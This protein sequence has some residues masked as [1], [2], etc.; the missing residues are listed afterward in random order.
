MSGVFDIAFVGGGIAA[1]S[2][3][4]FLRGRRSVIILESEEALGYHA[5]GRSAAEFAFRFHTPLAGKLAALSFPFLD[6]PPDGFCDG[7][8]LAPRGILLVAYA[9][10]QARL[11]EVQASEGGALESLTPE[12]ALGRAPILNP[13]GLAGALFDPECWDIDVEQLFQGYQRGVRTNGGEVRTRSAL[14]AAKR[15]AGLWHLETR[16]GKV[17]AR[18]VVN[19]SGAW[20]DETAGLCGQAPLGLMP[21]RRTAITVSPPEGVVLAGLPEIEDI[22]EDWYMK[23][24]AG[25]LLVSPADEHLSP[26][27]DARPEEIDV[28]WAM[29]HVHEAT[30]LRPERPD[31]AW[32]GLRTFA[33]DRA[34]IVGQRQTDDGFFWL[35]G[36]GGFGIQTSPALGLLAASILAR[37]PVPEDFAEFGTG[38]AK[39]SPN[40]FPLAPDHSG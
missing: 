25:K 28:A 20:A 40:R 22:D 11:A 21:L 3:A 37:D 35:A 2:A 31:H 39:L 32:A 19:A 15:Q 9:E 29:H 27:C 8:L 6:Q 10:K 1:L 34:P 26:P 13:E 12:Q 16:T 36:Q 4:Y 7:P 5:T 14:L 30:I 18:T 23:P 17:M 38:A 33:P 24:D